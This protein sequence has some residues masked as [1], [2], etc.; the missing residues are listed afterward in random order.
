MHHQSTA[1]NS[2][3][4]EVTLMSINTEGPESHRVA[5]TASGSG[6]RQEATQIDLTEAKG[7]TLKIPVRAGVPLWAWMGMSTGTLCTERT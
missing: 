2:S 3:Q 7:H 5:L 6:E 1:P 4:L